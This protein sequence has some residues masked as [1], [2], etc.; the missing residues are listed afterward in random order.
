MR[1]LFRPIALFV[2]M[3]IVALASSAVLAR[4]PAAPKKQP[5][6]NANPEHQSPQNPATQGAAPHSTKAASITILHPTGTATI[7]GSGNG[8]GR[9]LVTVPVGS[10]SGTVHGTVTGTINGSGN[11]GRETVHGTLTGATLPVGAVPAGSNSGTVHGTVTATITGSGN[12]GRETVHG[13]LTGATLPT[14][15]AQ[16][17]SN[18]GIVHGT[19]MGATLPV[20]SNNGV[21]HGTIV[22]VILPTGGKKWGGNPPRD[23]HPPMGH[24]KGNPGGTTVTY[25]G[26]SVPVATAPTA[27]NAAPTT[28]NPAATTTNVSPNDQAAS[29][30]NVPAGA[31]IKLDGSDFGAQ[32]GRVSIVMGNLVLPTVVV[33]WSE[34][35]VSLTLPQVEMTAPEAAKFVVRRANG[36]VANETPFQLSAMSK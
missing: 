5:G 21:I 12:G 26:G 6:P 22:G 16:A 15:A 35:E 19:L 9:P 36:S 31:T 1:H 10:N 24:G 27:D 17:G 34:T 8:T 14:G 2:T 23:P 11:G 18:N 13:T 33:N 32:Q 29:L 7:V 3:T 25:F 20:S 4:G 30:T 28:D